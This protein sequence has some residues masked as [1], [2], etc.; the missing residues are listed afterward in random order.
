MDIL[1]LSDKPDDNY[2]KLV[3]NF[4]REYNVR[5]N[6][7]GEIV[8]EIILYDIFSMIRSEYFSNQ[9]PYN[10]TIFSE[11]KTIKGLPENYLPD[12]LRK[13]KSFE[14]F[15]NPC[16]NNFNYLYLEISKCHSCNNILD[17]GNIDVIEN[18]FLKLPGE[19]NDSINN[20]IRYHMIEE[21]KNLYH[22]KCVK[23][24]SYYRVEKTFLN[25][26]NYLIITFRGNNNIKKHLD[27][28]LDLTDYKLINRG[29]NKYLLHSFITK[30]NFQYKAY[31]KEDNSWVS[32][33]DETTKDTKISISFDCIPYL[34]IYKGII[35]N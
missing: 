7:N 20:L 30:P 13:I 15:G 14:H 2:I 25:T 27:E 26:P 6:F 22:N 19:I 24:D 9:I 8:P 10:I 16:C 29:P 3:K 12:I 18:N 31:I 28:Q 11:L 34:A 35:L 4:I 17:F 21:N 32:Y 23:C 33:S 5:D 1:S